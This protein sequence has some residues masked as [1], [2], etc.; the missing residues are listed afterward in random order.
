MKRLLPILLLFAA[1]IAVVTFQLQRSSSR[2]GFL[3]PSFALPDLAGTIHRLEDYRGKVVFLNVWA[4]WCPPCREEMPSMNRLYQ[5]YAADGF[6]VLAISEDEGQ[7]EQV[8]AFVNDLRLT[9]PILL[10]PRGTIP[11]LYGVTGYPETFLIDRSGRI[12][13]HV[14]G[15]AD[16]FSD[17]ARAE[18]EQLLRAPMDESSDG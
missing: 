5:R 10:D 4:T 12:V 2:A 8:A 9:F 6:A 15:P 3:A 18:I 16:W 7:Q 11:P 17:S 13:R 1:L 14:V